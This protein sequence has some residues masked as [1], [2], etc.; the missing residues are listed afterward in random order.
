MLSVALVILI[1]LAA[2]VIAA[3]AQYIFKKSAKEFKLNIEGIINTFKRRST[4]LGL[5]M[6]LISLIVYLYALHE[7][8]IV[9][10][11]YPVFASSLIFVL[12]IS[13]YALKERVNLHRVLGIILILL[14]IVIISF[15]LT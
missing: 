15:T 14:G 2:A 11:V 3:A 9:S 13:M 1:T 8:P 12:L 5:T 4:L 7:T 6:Y 10:F